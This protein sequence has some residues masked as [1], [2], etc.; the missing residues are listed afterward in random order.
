MAR[1][2]VFTELLFFISLKKKQLK[3]KRTKQAM[4]QAQNNKKLRIFLFF[5]SLSFV[6]WLLINLSKTYTVDIP[7]RLN[8]ADLPAK[9]LFQNDPENTIVLSLKTAGFKIIKYKIKKNTLEYP[10]SNIRRSEN[11]GYFSLTQSNLTYLQSQFSDDAMVLK[12]KPDSLFFD[13]GEKSFKKVKVWAGE[14][15]EFRNG[16]NLVG[17]LNITPQLITL[18]GPKGILDTIRSVDLGSLDLRNNTGA[19]TQQVT[20][21]SPNPKIVLD[22]AEVTVKGRL[23][24]FTEGSFEVRYKVINIPSNAIIS[25]FP[26]EVKLVFQV[27]LSDYEKVNADGFE[28]ICDYNDSRNNKMDHLIPRVIKKPEFVSSVRVVPNKVEYLIKN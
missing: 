24:K 26:K 10:L 5:L 11:Q 20:L 7:F 23:D 27:P 12:I 19:F 25:T 4:E 9:K 6:F 28:V 3:Q 15:L 16:Y 21:Q 2:S 17:D 13:L 18:S 1:S 14:G 8:Y 22:P